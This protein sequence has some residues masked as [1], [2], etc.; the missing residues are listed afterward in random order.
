MGKTA[1]VDA[2]AEA[3]P[4]V[5]SEQ[6]IEDGG[7]GDAVQWI[8]ELF[9]HGSHKIAVNDPRFNRYTAVL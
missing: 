3:I 1:D 9:C 8:F 5:G 4:T 6:F 2:L 7:Q